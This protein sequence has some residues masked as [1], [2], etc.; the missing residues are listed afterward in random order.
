M[1]RFFEEERMPLHHC[2]KQ[3]DIF[4]FLSISLVEDLNKLVISTLIYRL[5]KVEFTLKLMLQVLLRLSAT[6]RR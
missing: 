5:S 2:F 4:M 1:T 3:C 6:L